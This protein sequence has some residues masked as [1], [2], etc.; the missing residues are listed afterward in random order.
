VG[1]ASGLRSGRRSGSALVENSGGLSDRQN[2]TTILI[3]KSTTHN[4]GNENAHCEYS[5]P[6]DEDGSC[7]ARCNSFALVAGR[8][9]VARIMATIKTAEFAQK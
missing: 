1:G 8:E 5:E 4:S 3:R 6:H 7:L 2:A 9:V